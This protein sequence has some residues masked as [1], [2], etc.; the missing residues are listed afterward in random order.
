MG[1]IGSLVGQCLGTDGVGVIFKPK[2]DMF[3][4][5]EDFCNCTEFRGK[6]QNPCKSYGCKVLRVQNGRVLNGTKMFGLVLRRKC[7]SSQR[8]ECMLEC[9]G[10]NMESQRQTYACGIGW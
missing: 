3:E 2:M 9:C 1:F 7:L 6:S 10:E 5:D 8:E 4:L